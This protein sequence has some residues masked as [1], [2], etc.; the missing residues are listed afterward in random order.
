MRHAWRIAIRF[1]RDTGFTG[2]FVGPGNQAS[3]AL[4]QA[5][6]LPPGARRGV[7]LP[8][9]PLNASVPVD[10]GKRLETTL[11]D[12]ETPWSDRVVP[13]VRNFVE[14]KSTACRRTGHERGRRRRW[15]VSRLP[16]AVRC[17][18]SS[19]CGCPTWVSQ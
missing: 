11:P 2:D 3:G 5:L 15:L 6:F 1:T 12:Y 10:P 4:G 16:P 14:Q 9:T 7:R 13:G 8:H 17:T 18:S 19:A